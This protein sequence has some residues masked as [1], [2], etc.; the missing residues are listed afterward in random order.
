MN[1]EEYRKNM[2]NRVIEIDYDTALL[3]QFVTLG[4][5]CSRDGNVVDAIRYKNKDDKD[6]R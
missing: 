4:G 3:K 5:E 2:R 1:T 6:E